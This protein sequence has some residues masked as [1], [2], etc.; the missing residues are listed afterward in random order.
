VAAALLLPLAAASARGQASCGTPTGGPASGAGAA[1][2]RAWA[3]PLD[4]T[5]TIRLD[6]LPLRAALDR[7]ADEARLRFSYSAELLPL[8]RRVCLVRDRV[9]VGDALGEMLAGTGIT[10]ISA[11]GSQV[12]LAPVRTESATGGAPA[13]ARAVGVLDRV[14]VTGTPTGGAHRSSPFAVEVLDGRTLAR[15]GVQSLAQALDAAVPGVWAWTQSPAGLLARYGSVRGASSFGVSAPKVY[16]DGVEV[17]NPLLLTRFDPAR[18]ERIEVIRGP[19]GAAL[20]GAD[21]ISGVVNIVTRHEGVGPDAPAAE[22]RASVGPSSSDYTTESVLVQDHALSLR[23]GTAARNAAL[24]VT[25]STV[26]EF[27]PG[28]SARQVMATGTARVVGARAVVTGTARL[29]ATSAGAQASPVVGSGMPSLAGRRGPRLGPPWD[30]GS[31]G[32]YATRPTEY[33]SGSGA[34]VATVPSRQT[35]RQYTLGGSATIQQSARWTHA[36][37]AGVDGYRLGGVPVDGL[38]IPSASDSALRA[39]R[40]GADRGTLRVSSTARLAGPDTRAATVTLALEHSTAREQT[41]AATGLIVPPSGDRGGP[42]D[43]P[44]AVWWSNTGALAQT[45]VTLNDA[46]FLSAGGRIEWIRGPADNTQVAL[47]P[48]L[49]GA[50]VRESGPVTVKL[51]TAFGRGIRPAR[52][53]TRGGT[54]MGGPPGRALVA[55]APEEQSGIEAGADLLVGRRLGL[56]VTRF[57][58]R[59]SG[60]IQPVAA[61]LPDTEASGGPHHRRVA[62]ELQNVG[63]IL[64][65]GWELKASGGAGP[66]SL[67]GTLSL[68]DSRVGRL[69]GGYRGDLRAGDRMLEVPARTAS[70]SVAWTAPRWAASWAIARASDWINYDRAAIAADLASGV[71][72]PG[73]LAGPQLRAYWR[74][75]EG[76]TRMRATTSLQ[77]RRGVALTIAG[78][79]L[80]DL[81]RGEPDNLTVLPG[82]TVTLG[83]RTAF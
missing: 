5:V 30:A 54:W 51:R 77:L 34:E 12:V 24:G 69:A 59:A 72:A 27:V 38:P 81:Q 11:G 8:D 82:R 42:A 39:A 71:R 68:V 79:N 60:L 18:L 17:A 80:L 35:E 32:S 20:Y 75:Y 78:D 66:L 7:L 45:Q 46:L 64:N 3:P 21:A 28:V 14:I 16:I 25:V 41:T 4:R 58:Q 73:D 63:E 26:G 15:Q 47:L 49:G 61:A 9:S 53:V 1:P 55:L 83:V 31:P 13:L 56:H 70:L 67:V 22:L 50:Y 36:V 76:V 40:G 23:T 57:D 19:Q 44:G 37:V 48:M 2:A 29:N 33:D 6:D 10:P 43:A 74:E 65:R 62:Y 52:S